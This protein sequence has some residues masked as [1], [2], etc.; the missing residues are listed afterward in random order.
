[1]VSILSDI[2]RIQRGKTMTVVI[3]EK[4]LHKRM[5][6]AHIYN[7]STGNGIALSHGLLVKLTALNEDFVCLQVLNSGIGVPIKTQTWQKSVI[8]KPEL[9]KTTQVKLADEKEITEEAVI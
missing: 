8:K 6:M 2:K 3:A 9:I 4:V 7:G 1:M 5:L